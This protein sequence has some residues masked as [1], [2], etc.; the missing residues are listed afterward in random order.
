VSR[1]YKKI[2]KSEFTKDNF[3]LVVIRDADKESI[4][5]WRNEQIEILR[6]KDFLTAGQQETYFKNVIDHL[7]EHEEPSQLIFSF[8]ENGI[9]IGY[10][11]L[12]HI[13]WKNKTAEVSFL[14]ETSRNKSTEI[15]IND[16]INYLALIKKVAN[17]FLN[18]NSIFTYAYD[19]RPNLYRALEKSGF[20]ETSRLKDHVEINGEKKDVVIHTFFMNPL[21]MDLAVE[22]QVDL[23]FNWANDPEVRKFSFQQSVIKYEDHV[24][25]FTSKI[26]DPRFKFYLFK[27]QKG[28][29]VGQV[30]INRSDEETIIGISIDVNHRGFGY[31]TKMLVLAC[32]DYFNSEKTTGITAYIKSE[33]AASISIFKKAGFVETNSSNENTTNTLKLILRNE[34]F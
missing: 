5:Q 28:E 14:T 10:G 22:E 20:K 3:S 25:W 27:N 29:P 6:Q 16:W 2:H 21:V 30:R 9:L 26:K 18:F 23:Y 8:L 24:P 33:N 31:G 7:F 13:D 4:R 32:S 15:F 34:R 1:S 11:G 19:L 17:T 12:V